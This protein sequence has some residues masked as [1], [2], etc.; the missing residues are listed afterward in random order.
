MRFCS[1]AYVFLPH[2]MSFPDFCGFLLLFSFPCIVLFV[3]FGLAIVLSVLNG[4]TP[5]AYTFIIFNLVKCK[6]TVHIYTYNDTKLN[7]VI[8]LYSFVFSF[9]LSFLP[10]IFNFHFHFFH[11]ENYTSKLNYELFRHFTSI[12]FRFNKVF[13]TYVKLDDGP[14]PGGAHHCGTNWILFEES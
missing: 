14:F 11:S 8:L 6:C 3:L 13:S 7:Y 12:H 4:F 2:Q 9:S 10:T 5:S 1:M